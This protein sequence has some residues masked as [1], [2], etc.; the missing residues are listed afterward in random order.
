MNAHSERTWLRILK[1]TTFCAATGV[2]SGITLLG[3][4]FTPDEQNGWWAMLRALLYALWWLPTVLFATFWLLHIYGLTFVLS[5]VGILVEVRMGTSGRV[6]LRWAVVSCLCHL[7]L[8]INAPLYEGISH[9][10][11]VR[12]AILLLCPSMRYLIGQ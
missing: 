8:L 3:M 2:V 10:S 7:A 5:L 1:V 4:N 12:F 9:G 6:V 11:V